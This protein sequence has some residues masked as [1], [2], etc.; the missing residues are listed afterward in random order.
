MGHVISFVNQICGV[1]KSTVILQTAAILKKRGSQVLMVDFDPQS[2]LTKSFGIEPAEGLT[3]F[4]LLNGSVKVDDILIR[5]GSGDLLPSDYSLGLNEKNIF[6]AIGR[7]FLLSNALADVVKKYDY[8]LI[9]CPP[10]K[11]VLVYNAL[12]ASS[13]AVIVTDT[14]KYNLKWLPRQF[15]IF[16]EIE[17]AFKKK[18]NV[19]GVLLSKTPDKH[20]IEK[21][22][23]DTITAVATEKKVSVFNTAIFKG[24]VINE[25]LAC[26]RS[27]P[28]YA[29]THELT[30]KYESFVDELTRLFED[31]KK[32]KNK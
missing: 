15:D 18:I 19:L 31:K 8:V 29:P 7:V 13:C 2:G 14:S 3:V 1:G 27:L 25:A 20:R 30:K 23:S 11:S 5:T 32:R 28:D 26:Y 21:S 9:D 4:E 22:L 24:N 17:K 16:G 12:V 10:S 6:D